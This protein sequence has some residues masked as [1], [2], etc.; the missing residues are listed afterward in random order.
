MGRRETG[1]T[2]WTAGAGPVGWAGRAY[3]QAW[4]VGP[5]G[6]LAGPSVS[7]V[8][9]PGMGRGP[10]EA[11]RAGTVRARLPAFGFR[12]RTSGRGISELGARRLFPGA[13]C[14]PLLSIPFG[15]VPGSKIFTQFPR[16]RLPPD[17][18]FQG[19]VCSPRPAIP[20]SSVS[21]SKI[22]THFPRRRLPPAA[23]SEAR[24]A[25]RSSLALA[26]PFRG[27]KSSHNSRAPCCPR[28]A[29]SRRGLLPAPR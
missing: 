23:I 22:F 25:P 29:F 2:R 4:W 9:P 6:I 8:G 27:A 19:A 24:F 28:P 11:R 13:V 26:A 5:P 14:S 17:R 12:A 16:R 18:L 15:S 10:P 20:C 1:R 21:G 7:K 3:L